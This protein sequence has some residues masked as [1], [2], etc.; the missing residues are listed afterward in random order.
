MR[1]FRSKTARRRAVLRLPTSDRRAGRCVIPCSTN[2]SSKR[3]SWRAYAS[4]LNAGHWV[5][6]E[7]RPFGEAVL[8]GT[9]FLE[10]ARA[11][12][13]VEAACRPIQIS[14]VYFLVP[15]VFKD[16]ETKEIR[17]ILSKRDDGFAFVVI[18]RVEAD[19][20]EWHEHA[21]GDIAFL[22]AE[23]PSGRDLDDVERCCR[24]AD[25]NVAQDTSVI[26]ERFRGFAPHWR[27]MERLR[28]GAGE[29]LATFR[30]ADAFAPETDALPL[31]PALADVATGFMS[32]VEGFEQG[33]PFGYRR[34]RLWR[35]LSARVHSHVQ[36][37][38]NSQP[39]ERSYDATIMDQHGNVLVDVA[40]FT[41]R[42]F[43]SE[44]AQDPRQQPEDQ[45]NF[46]VEIE[47]PGSI[48]TLGLRSDV[49]RSPG[50]G[51]AEI[52]VGAA[53]LNFIEVLYA[54]GM[55]PE[56]PGGNVRFGLECAGRIVALGGES[57]GSGS[58]MPCSA[59]CRKRSAVS[60]SRPRRRSH[61]SPSRSRLRKPRPFRPLTQP[62]TTPWL[63]AAGCSAASAY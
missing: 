8:P 31:H 50:P 11:A 53:G 20:D 48:A 9:A 61:S 22:T 55:L 7:H 58:A 59:S 54:L 4:F 39:E 2:A 47:R 36:S 38:E 12:L 6:D 19:A 24:R 35:P 57:P 49:R 18:S 23:P 29:G 15:L 30:L 21:R 28:V 42:R 52:E 37:V 14:D 16:G 1:S 32:V 40:G 44:V 63:R 45:W 3:R 13:D 46:C 43:R 33:V 51:E 60:P 26:F 56:P 34:L 41:L 5:L 10:L 62:P 27:T 25:I 17:T